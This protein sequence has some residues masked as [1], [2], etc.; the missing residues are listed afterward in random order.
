MSRK[1]MDAIANSR[2]DFLDLVRAAPASY[3]E[4]YD[5]VPNGELERLFEE[6]VTDEL[7][8]RFDMQK[9][10]EAGYSRFCALND[11]ECK[12]YKL[13]Q[14]TTEMPIPYFASYVP[15]IGRIDV[16]WTLD[17]VKNLIA[18]TRKEK[19]LV[20]RLKAEKGSGIVGRIRV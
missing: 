19:E 3:Y 15:S 16:A 18:S 6:V 17:E 13:P 4:V 1:Y 14:N 5:G 9:H 10:T 2:E 11:F 8:L 20:R 7:L 12:V